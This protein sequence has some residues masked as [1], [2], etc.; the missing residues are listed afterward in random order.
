VDELTGNAP[1]VA[2]TPA[3]SPPPTS[4]SSASGTTANTAPVVAPER[5]ALQRLQAGENPRDVNKA[6]YGAPAKSAPA[7]P[8]TTDATKPPQPAL[9]ADGTP[10]AEET[11]G[12]EAKELAAL[13]RGKFDAELLKHMPLSNRK[14]IAKG[15][16]ASQ[17]EADRQFQAAKNG[18]KPT[19]EPAT[20]DA[21]TT[22]ATDPNQPNAGKQDVATATGDKG[23]EGKDAPA[24]TATAVDPFSA[25]EFPASDYET[26]VDIGGEEFAKTTKGQFEALG[27]HMQ[28]AYQ[29]LMGL[30]SYA[31][32]RFENADFSEALTGLKKTPGFES[33]DSNAEHV[34]Q[35]REK[36][37]F[38]VR[39]AADPRSYSFKEAVSDA[40]ASLFRNNVNTAAQ[41]QLL[42]GRQ[43]SLN[44]APDKGGPR[45]TTPRPMTETDRMRA[46]GAKLSQGMSPAQARAAVDAA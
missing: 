46:I 15:L 31:M 4:Q 37:T 2:S 27:R 21:A 19:G 38:L 16:A 29:P 7:T 44:S 11:Y 18:G 36:A 9:N 40:A 35:L 25:Y 34:A 20:G 3:A 10:K 12:L 17:A 26:L 14:A 30:V 41:A 33:I 43:A 32:E 24:S 28:A 1:E 22:A 5:E 45:V 8:A 23:K 6:L 13:K 39:T 42:R